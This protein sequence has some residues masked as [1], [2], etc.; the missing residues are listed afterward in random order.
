MVAVVVGTVWKVHGFYCS[1]H[2]GGS[3]SLKDKSKISNLYDIVTLTLVYRWY[4][5]LVNNHMLYEGMKLRNLTFTNQVHRS[6]LLYEFI[7]MKSD[8]PGVVR[9]RIWPHPRNPDWL[10]DYIVCYVN[11]HITADPMKWWKIFNSIRHN[12]KNFDF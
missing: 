12:L 5:H 7:S 9:S 6:P 2:S 1:P 3:W 10:I 8:E 11:S 4:R